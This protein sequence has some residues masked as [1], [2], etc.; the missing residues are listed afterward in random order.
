LPLVN[1]PHEIQQ[2]LTWLAT[3]AFCLDVTQ[4]RMLAFSTTALMVQVLG[5][6][7]QQQHKPQLLKKS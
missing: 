7:F 1:T 4:R 6:V 2:Q 5:R 3:F